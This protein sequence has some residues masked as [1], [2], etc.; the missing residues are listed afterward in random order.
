M[1]VLLEVVIRRGV[2]PKLLTTAL[3]ATKGIGRAAGPAAADNQV[4]DVESQIDFEAAVVDGV[5]SWRSSSVPLV[6]SRVTVVWARAVAA[7][8]AVANAKAATAARNEL[9]RRRAAVVMAAVSESAGVS[10]SVRPGQ[11]RL[12]GVA[13]GPAATT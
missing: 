13:A 2:P 8:N 1:I 6:P 10:A 7:V 11:P 4:F 5:G 3:A 9:A 12:S